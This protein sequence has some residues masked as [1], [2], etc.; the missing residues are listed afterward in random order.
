M[1]FITDANARRIIQQTEI[2]SVNLAGEIFNRAIFF[3]SDYEIQQLLAYK[4]LIDDTEVFVRDTYKP[5]V[6]KK[7][8]YRYVYEYDEEMPAFHKIL[9][10]SHL[11]KDYENFTIPDDIRYKENR[12]LNFTK[13]NEFR[14]WFPTVEHLFKNDKQAFVF[15]LKQKF[16]I[17]TNPEALEAA[18]SGPMDLVNYDITELKDQINLKIK[19]A[20]RFYYASNKNTTILKRFSKFSYLGFIEEPIRNNDT[21]YTDEELKLFLRDY[22]QLI[23][24]PIKILLREYYR[25]QYNPDLNF[26]SELLLFLNFKPCSK[27]YKDGYTKEEIDP[28]KGQFR[29]HDKVVSSMNEEEFFKDYMKFYENKNSTKEKQNDNNDLPF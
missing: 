11:N 13:I 29:V 15:R 3:F 20:G 24:K 28:N 12:Q 16:G 19:L 8:S 6:L 9:E 22:H 7:D 25:I 14:R 1:A 27:C 17:I 2:N 18:N 21:G 5:I 26:N 4:Q 23:K 10:C